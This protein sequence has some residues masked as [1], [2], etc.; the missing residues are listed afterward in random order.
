MC[1]ITGR[2]WRAENASKPDH[3][4]SFHPHIFNEH[5]LR[6][7]RCAECWGCDRDQRQK[8]QYPMEFTSHRKPHHYK[9]LYISGT[10]SLVV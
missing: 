2:H 5:L 1:E 8:V 7:R 6:A 4:P 3:L 10:A 9:K